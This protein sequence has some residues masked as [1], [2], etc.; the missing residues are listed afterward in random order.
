[1]GCNI[2]CIPAM[3]FAS[4]VVL[5][6]FLVPAA[7]FAWEPVKENLLDRLTALFVLASTLNN[8]F[9]DCLAVPNLTIATKT[10]LITIAHSL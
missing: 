7:F 9:G 6:T 1:M 3:S 8:V 5:L 10:P 2:V 4:S